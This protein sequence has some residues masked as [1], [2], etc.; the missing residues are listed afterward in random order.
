MCAICVRWVC[1]G[2]V[3]GCAIGVTKAKEAEVAT[4]QVE[5][6]RKKNERTRRKQEPINGMNGYQQRMKALLALLHN[7]TQQAEERR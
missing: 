1:D 3:M 4:K 6:K 2:H 5:K 7:T